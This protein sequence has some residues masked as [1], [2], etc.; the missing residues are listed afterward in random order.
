MNGINLFLALA[1]VQL[2]CLAGAIPE[3]TAVTPLPAERLDRVLWERVL[4]G[5]QRACD[6]TGSACA[7]RPPVLSG[8]TADPEDA[9]PQ[10]QLASLPCL[11]QGVSELKFSDFFTRPV[12]PRGLE[13]SEKLR[14]LNGCRVRL[15][16][17]MVR[18]E[19]PAFGRLLL[20]PFPAQIHA[21]D[22]ELA[23]DLPA[24]IVHVFVPDA[25]GKA[26]PF[27]P[28]LLLLTGALTVGNRSEDDGRISVVRLSLDP[29]VTSSP[30]ADA[31]SANP[32]D[33]SQATTQPQ[34]LLK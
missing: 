3:P 32:R 5:A 14:R 20:A 28:K 1:F 29:P 6:S 18:E 2:R 33:A 17:Y 8:P 11:P 15:L 13:I 10:S 31:G 24:S 9:S 30:S 25:Q 4:A 19:R 27:T 7:G 26:L 23:D 34:P 22:C 12:G 21:H 16:G